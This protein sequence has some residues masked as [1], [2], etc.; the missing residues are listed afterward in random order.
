[1]NLKMKVEVVGAGGSAWRGRYLYVNDRKVAHLGVDPDH[2]VKPRLFGSVM[3]KEFHLP[4]PTLH[5]K[6]PASPL[7]MATYKAVHRFWH[8]VDGRYGWG[9][10]AGGL[11]LFHD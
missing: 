11:P 10:K 1:M 8:N 9:T 4:L 6:S 7:R 5:F 2:G 3:G